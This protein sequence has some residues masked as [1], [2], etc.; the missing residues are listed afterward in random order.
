MFEAYGPKSPSNA[1]GR[2]GL[3]MALTKFSLFPFYTRLIEE[4][5]YE[6]VLSRPSK[7]GNAKATAAICYPCQI[8]HGAVHDLLEREVDYVFL[9]H[10]IEMEDTNGGLHNY[11]CPSTTQIPDII[12]AAFNDPSKRILSPHLG[13]SEP[14]RETTMK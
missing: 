3:P 13:L 9:P 2:I 5:G 8:M 14:L 4:L 6:V 10:V 12:R 1:R 11:T 7:D